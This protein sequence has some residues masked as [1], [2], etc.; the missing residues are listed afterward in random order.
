MSD[1][2]EAPFVPNLGRD[3]AAR[4]APRTV[5][6]G[7][8]IAARA[9][10]TRQP[11]GTL[12][13]SASGFSRTL[14]LSQVQRWSMVDH[15]AERVGG[16]VVR[17]PI[18]YWPFADDEDAT[19]TASRREV[20]APVVTT[21]HS[22][23]AKRGRVDRAEALRRMLMGGSKAS[24]QATGTQPAS[25]RPTPARQEHRPIARRDPGHR[26]L[27][28]S[29]RRKGRTWAGPGTAPGRTSTTAAPQ[30]T[31]S[32]PTARV[33]PT[34]AERGERKAP[35]DGSKEDR[36][37]VA[38]RTRSRASQRRRQPGAASVTDPSTTLGHPS[39][40]GTT[41]PES[42]L[43]RDTALGRAI[44]P[45]PRPRPADDAVHRALAPD[46]S[47]TALASSDRLSTSPRTSGSDLAASGSP[48]AREA[49]PIESRGQAEADGA[50]TRAAP[51]PSALDEPL[52]RAESVADRAA[53]PLGRTANESAA[54]LTSASELPVAP[55]AAAAAEAAL[56]SA[57]ETAQRETEIAQRSAGRAPRR[58]V[59]ADTDSR[60]AAE[61][62]RPLPLAAVIRRSTPLAGQPDSARTSASPRNPLTG[63]ASS[64]TDPRGA[65]RATA[66]PSMRIGDARGVRVQRSA[67]GRSVTW[68]GTLGTASDGAITRDEP[69]ALPT[70][71]DAV[72]TA[73]RALDRALHDE[74]SAS[75]E[76][77]DEWGS[78]IV[79]APL[80]ARRPLAVPVADT[81][82]TVA[83][84]DRPARAN[85][86]ESAPTP[87]RP[88][89]RSIEPGHAATQAADRASSPERS[90]STPPAAD[91]R[92]QRRGPERAPAARRELV[93]ATPG[94]LIGPNLLRRRPLHVARA[95][96]SLPLL[97]G[98]PASIQSDLPLGSV[99][100]SA[101]WHRHG[102]QSG[103]LLAERTV[104][105]SLQPGSAGRSSADQVIAPTDERTTT[106]VRRSADR[107]VAAS[108][109]L[110]SDAAVAP[111]AVP[112]VR[113]DLGG[114]AAPAPST[115]TPETGT[116]DRIQRQAA[117]GRTD[118]LVA[119]SP[120]AQATDLAERFLA[121][122]VRHRDERPA[123][124]PTVFRSIADVI[125][126]DR[127]PLVSTSTASR[128]ALAAVGKSAAT[129]GDVIH[130]AEPV[131]AGSPSGR[132]TAL[133]AH[134][135][136]HVAHPSPEPR[137]FDDDRDSAEERRA[138]EVGELMR[139]APLAP[140]VIGASMS[141]QRTIDPAVASPPPRSGG[142]SAGGD[143]ISAA[144][145]A[146]RLG[147][148]S[149]DTI[150]RSPASTSYSSSSS[151]SSSSVIR[152]ERMDESESSE[153][154]AQQ[155]VANARSTTNR[156][157][158]FESQLRDH[159]DL[160]V[161]LLEER[162]IRDLERRGGRFR[163][164]F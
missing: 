48:D 79:E 56:E 80:R 132:L 23:T 124:L 67:D 149:S 100:P 65:H 103:E 20:A 95:V 87:S 24:G 126:G 49:S 63:A 120:R 109:D 71:V 116:Q 74:Q 14:G 3:V 61:V 47:P 142:G 10:I 108:V 141:A 160:I 88:I 106:P 41:S 162:I 148:G 118:Q 133:M 125:V 76:A 153:Q 99:A 156:P 111:R 121:E 119:G 6:A 7:G 163:G 42:T 78:P 5:F 31:G 112:V 155:Q 151:S 138:H 127:R 134:E 131:S 17:P 73:A 110:V 15:P 55:S 129:T 28:I 136:T 22:P 115:S 26:G 101:N 32:V 19:G 66:T 161:D 105:R 86:R 96:G 164:D 81:A 58:P 69:A 52:T 146:A 33:E 90:R 85:G 143:T 158:T 92:V 45:A 40:V 91:D 98:S 77:A 27:P 60:T 154:E 16:A 84:G 9:G 97:D 43:V 117:L 8:S 139:T 37:A 4:C 147:G 1:V 145:L 35:A 157:Q 102:D 53:E 130:L 137:F 122:L 34:R 18:D 114:H 89:Q 12:G 107:A 135:L 2:A 93:P 83:E 51:L 94:S 75:F 59:A 68:N 123:E 25:A 113:R 30:N 46:A 36:R 54:A 38:E 39:A 29:M 128:R 152:R 70:V 140:R 62:L 144:G 11:I 82:G 44:D 64:A 13:R 72:P 150:R 57:R 159:F 50:L 104:A 21:P